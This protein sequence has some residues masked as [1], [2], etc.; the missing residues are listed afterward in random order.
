MGLVGRGNDGGPCREKMKE[1]LGGQAGS[2]GA[3][4]VVLHPFSNVN[5]R[6]VGCAV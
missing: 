4:Q 5:D 1:L 6:G 2:M 3:Q